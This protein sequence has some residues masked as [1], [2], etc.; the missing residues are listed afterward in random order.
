MASIYDRIG[1]REAVAVA[2]D[3]FYERVRGDELLASYFARRDMARQKAHMRA[4][5]A[6]AIGGPAIYAGRDMGAAHAGLGVTSAAFDRVVKHL[7]ATL[8][9]LGVRSSIVMAIV[10]KLAPLRD[11]IVAEPGRAAA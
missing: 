9:A 7:V 6:T 2:V 5:L 1:G 3:D 11:Q 4:F 10:T 8:N